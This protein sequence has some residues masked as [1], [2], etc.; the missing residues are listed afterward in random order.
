MKNVHSDHSSKGV[1]TQ[2]SVFVGTW[3]M[4]KHLQY[5]LPLIGV[6]TDLC[7]LLTLPPPL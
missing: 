3:N 7:S 6:K 1:L 2:I 4:G 5:D